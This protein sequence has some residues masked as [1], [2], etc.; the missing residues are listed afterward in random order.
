MFFSPLRAGTFSEKLEHL[1]ETRRCLLLQILFIYYPSSTFVDGYEPPSKNEMRNLS[2]IMKTIP[3]SYFTFAELNKILKNLGY[4]EEI[5]RRMCKAYQEMV[6][7]HPDAFYSG[8]PRKLYHMA[9]CKVRDGLSESY[10]FPFGIDKLELVESCKETLRLTAFRPSME[11]E[12][13]PQ[14]V[15]QDEMF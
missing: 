10:N 6:C 12:R 8:K 1:S 3:D 11:F 2:L 4:E 7:E 14:L 13:V 15:P 9:L 5:I